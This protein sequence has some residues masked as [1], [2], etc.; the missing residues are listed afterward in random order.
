MMQ[1]SDDEADVAIVCTPLPVESID[2]DR[3]APLPTKMLLVL[4]RGLDTDK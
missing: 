2:D 1:E 4:M 3:F